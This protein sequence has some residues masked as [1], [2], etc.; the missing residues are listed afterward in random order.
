VVDDRS[1]DYSISSPGLAHYQGIG[2]WYQGYVVS[3][4]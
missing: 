4:G 2:M 3:G 1:G